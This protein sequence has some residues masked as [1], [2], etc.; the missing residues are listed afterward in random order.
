MYKRQVLKIELKNGGYQL[1]KE[2]KTDLE[3]QKIVREEFSIPVE[4]EFTGMLSKTLEDHQQMIASADLSA[5]EMP[6]PPMDFDVPPA[7][8]YDVPPSPSAPRSEPKRKTQTVNLKM[9]FDNIP[10]KTCLL[11]T[12]IRNRAVRHLQ[13]GRI[14][15]FGCGTGNPF[16]ST[17]PAA[18]L[19]AAE[20]EADI[21]LKASLVDGVYDKD[22]NVSSCLLYTSRC[23]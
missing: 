4:V 11:Y 10:I 13:K 17:D 3:I 19:R 22:T 16:F 12:S 21:V 8:G 5:G 9:A 2:A 14:V 7:G 20:I 15:I 18:D 23:V 1:L 6:P